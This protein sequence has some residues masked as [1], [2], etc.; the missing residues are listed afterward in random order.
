MMDKDPKKRPT[1]KEIIDKDIIQRVMKEYFS[2]A[3]NANSPNSKL[4]SPPKGFNDK[5]TSYLGNVITGTNYAS[6]V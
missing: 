6:I 1:A 2:F 3:A 5:T 4:D